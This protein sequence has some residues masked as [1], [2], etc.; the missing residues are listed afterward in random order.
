[1]S[2]E[3]DPLGGYRQALSVLDVAGA[4]AEQEAWR[5]ARDVTIA[6]SLSIDPCLEP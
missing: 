6:S 1:M 3:G 4:A 5:T 2:S